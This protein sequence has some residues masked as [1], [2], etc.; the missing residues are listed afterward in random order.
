MINGYEIFVNEA[1]DVN[2]N[3]RRQGFK[4]QKQEM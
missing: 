3:F 1:P 2:F 4:I